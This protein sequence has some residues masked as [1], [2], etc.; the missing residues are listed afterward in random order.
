[1]LDWEDA[2]SVVVPF[3]R[4]PSGIAHGCRLDSYPAGFLLPVALWWL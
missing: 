2:I 4:S 1:M 3:A